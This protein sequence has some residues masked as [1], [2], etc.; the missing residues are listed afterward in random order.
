MARVAHLFILSPFVVHTLYQCGGVDYVG[1]LR[2]WVDVLNI[3][4]LLLFVLF[5]VLIFF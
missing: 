2:W 1:D 4:L 5:F 3:A